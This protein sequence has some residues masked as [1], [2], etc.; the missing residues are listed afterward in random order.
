MKTETQ[1]QFSKKVVSIDLNVPV[2]Y[3][4]INLLAF[5][6]QNTYSVQHL[7]WNTQQ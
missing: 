5:N 4:E 3:V 1:T 7:K 2:K 6:S